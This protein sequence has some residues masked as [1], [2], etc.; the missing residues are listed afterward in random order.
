MAPRRIVDQLNDGQDPEEIER[1]DAPEL[2]AVDDADDDDAG[3]DDDEDQQQD[4]Q[5]DDEDDETPVGDEPSDEPPL[6]VRR[7]PSRRET[8]V[9]AAR[10]RAQ[11]AERR[12]RDLELELARARNGG[13]N[14]PGVESE[15]VRSARLA[16]MEPSE[17]IEYLLNEERQQRLRDR[18]VDNFT[19]NDRRDRD[20]FDQEAKRNPTY[21]K[22]AGEVEH[23]LQLLRSQGQNVPRETI[24]KFILGERVLT[25]RSSP[26][27]KQQRKDAERRVARQNVTLPNGKGERGSRGGSKSADL[28][29]RLANVPI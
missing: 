19:A 4:D 17:R 12:A 24:L 13:R 9:A 25:N 23:R 26:T 22:Y 27:V 14:D 1:D 5:Q 15:A 10:R 3:P 21:R 18:Q 2:E 29:K 7:Q 20:L 28:E 6:N 8:A 11:A 16:A